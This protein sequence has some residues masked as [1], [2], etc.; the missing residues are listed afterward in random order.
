M[1]SQ[2]ATRLV[3]RRHTLS[4]DL[5]LI[6]PMHGLGLAVA[7]LPLVFVAS[8][9]GM[10]TL[11]TPTASS[12]VATSAVSEGT[13]LLSG[14][15]MHGVLGPFPDT[16]PRCFAGLFP[17]E[18]FDFSLDAEGPIEVAVAWEGS[19]RAVFVQLYWE[20]RWLAHED[21]APAGG[22]SQIVFLRK[23]MEANR[24]QLRLVSR[25]P[26]QAIPF[27]LVLKY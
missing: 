27:T 25:E 17:C 20:G 4:R 15:E 16:A 9:G 23:M 8:C 1:V 5:H 6:A 18:T 22:P 12:A 24:Y 13:S 10:T 19:S 21:V 2:V 14:R 11:T 7:T 3:E 26:A